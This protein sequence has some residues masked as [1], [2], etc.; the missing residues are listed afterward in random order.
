MDTARAGVQLP[1]AGSEEETGALPAYLPD[2]GGVIWCPSSGVKMADQREPGW[3]GAFQ[4]TAFSLISYGLHAVGG[5][6]HGGRF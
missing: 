6:E 2:E 5:K 4:G 3:P 1:L